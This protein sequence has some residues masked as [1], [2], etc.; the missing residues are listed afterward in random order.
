MESLSDKPQICKTATTSTLGTRMPMIG[1]LSSATVLLFAN[2]TATAGE[3]FRPWMDN[4]NVLV[5]DPY[6]A[7]ELDLDK[8]SQDKRVIGIIHRASLGLCSVDRKYQSRRIDA[9]KHGYLWGSYHLLT[10]DDIKSQ[11]NCY[12]NIAGI[13]H[14]ETYAIDVE[15][16]DSDNDCK[17]K[18]YKVKPAQVVMALKYFVDKTGQT[19][20]L[21]INGSAKATLAGVIAADHSLRDLRLWYARYRDDI[22]SYFPDEQWKTYTLW[23]FS[24]EINCK[25]SPGECPYR[26]PGT[27]HDMDINVFFGSEQRLQELWPLNVPK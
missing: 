18:D 25:P 19:P 22:S 1:A 14:D 23:Q 11:I 15:C 20:L 6:E 8:V 5:L 17:R 9:K 3:L 26:V 27:A 24:S 7:N 21:Y 12:L 13:N 10:T 2:I 4:A 16:L